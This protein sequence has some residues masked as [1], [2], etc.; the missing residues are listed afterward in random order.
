MYV[1]RRNKMA[2]KIGRNDPC[3]CGCGKKYKVCHEAFD[4]KIARFAAQGH[5]VPPREIIKTP[6]QIAKIKESA[7]INM[8]V[9]DYIGE[10]IHPDGFDDW[11]KIH[12]HATVRFS[13]RGS[14]GEGARS[15][16]AEFVDVK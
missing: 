15:R 3:W 2:V 13:E 16:R 6:E 5:R 4:A 8:A 9:L 11:G 1:E 7:K 14:Y 10:H 12:A